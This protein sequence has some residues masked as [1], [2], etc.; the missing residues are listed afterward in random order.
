MRGW[1]LRRTTERNEMMALEEVATVFT[2][3]LREA[4]SVRARR[5]R[6]P[7]GSSAC[8]NERWWQQ[9]WKK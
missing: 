2:N 1:S 8:N 4:E 3:C 6:R 7:M 9:T 5:V